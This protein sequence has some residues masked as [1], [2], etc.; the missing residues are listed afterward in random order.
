MTSEKYSNPLERQVISLPDLC[1]DQIKSSLAGA[2]SA[3]PPE[4]LKNIR[5]I[6][7]TGCGD[8]YMAAHAVLPAFKRYA[9]VFGMGFEAERCIDVARK[10]EINPRS[11]ANTM[12]VAISASGSPARIKEALLNAKSQGAVTMAVTNNPDSNAGKAADYVFHVGT[13]AFPNPNP[14]LRNYYASLVSLFIFAAYFGE[15]KGISPEG[16][17]NTLCGK[18]R[19]YTKSFEAVIPEID[20]QMFNLAG[21]WQHFDG[22]DMLGDHTDHSTASFIGAKFV[23]VAGIMCAACDTENWCHVEFFKS[24]PEE[25]G[26]VIVFRGNGTNL[27][28]VKE[29]LHQAQCVNRPVL[30]ITDS[31]EEFD[32][33]D[34]SMICRLP[35][36][37][38]NFEFLTPAMNYVPGALLASYYSAL[39]EEPYFRNG[40]V[41]AE[42]NTIKSSKIIF[43]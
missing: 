40:G 4:I 31:E 20:S 34:T 37:P 21:A 25:T 2:R 26:T 8:S 6:I 23:E 9:N 1:D 7:F 13:P 42:A 11:A 12:V 17:L 29:T 43:G 36:P 22:F 16:S 33:K 19:E 32:L 30:L 41:F 18:I 35:S 27:S 5:Q 38:E 28:R 14:G 24:N 39:N 3:V 15:T 10:L